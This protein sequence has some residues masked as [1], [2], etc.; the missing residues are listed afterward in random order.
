MSL[1]HFL[2][3]FAGGKRRGEEK[4]SKKMINKVKK[5]PKALNMPAIFVCILRA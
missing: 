4:M 5:A 1:Y 3:I 2:C